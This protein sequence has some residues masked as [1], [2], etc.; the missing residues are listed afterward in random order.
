MNIKGTGRYRIESSLG[1]GPSG[2]VYKAWDHEFNRFVAIKTAHKGKGHFI[3][4]PHLAGNLVHPNIVTIY[5]V[6]SV[7]DV[8]YVSMEYVNGPDLRTFC[9]KDMMLKPQKVIEIMIKVLKGVFYGHGKGFI[10]KNIKP[11]NIILNENG[12]PKITDFG[13]AQA[14]G[15][16]RQMGFWGSPDYISP[17]QLKGK[18]VTVH[19]DI[20]SLGCVL[21]ELLKGEK[22]FH[23][24]SQYAVINKI[25]N[26]DPEPLGETLLCSGALM[27]IITKALSKDPNA[28]Y[29]SCSDFA[30]DLSK[31]LGLINQQQ[32]LKKTSVFRTITDRV[33]MFKDSAA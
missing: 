8:S 4:E 14:A 32:Q 21:Y 3:A 1:Q 28:R 17:E 33:N 19:S 12:V 7:C 26:N 11:S 24:E 6:E 27:D 13:I 29:Q 30:F 16:T 18:A 20:F 23:G 22:P 15:K 2:T 31:V 10:H 5:K 25:M 9:E